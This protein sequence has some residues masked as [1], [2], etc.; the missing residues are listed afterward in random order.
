LKKPNFA[1]CDY[2]CI[3]PTIKAGILAQTD[4]IFS[5]AG[6]FAS[7]TKPDFPVFSST[8]RNSDHNKNRSKT[9]QIKSDKAILQNVSQPLLKLIANHFQFLIFNFQ[10]I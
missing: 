7:G 5:Q 10:L 6:R 2:I 8:K 4:W 3:C 9:T 1:N